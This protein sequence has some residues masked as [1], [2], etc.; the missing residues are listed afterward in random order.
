[1]N[2][3]DQPSMYRGNQQKGN[4]WEVIGTKAPA[5][6]PLPE[7]SSSPSETEQAEQNAPLQETGPTEDPSLMPDPTQDNA[8]EDTESDE[9][10]LKPSP[11]EINDGE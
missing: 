9:G 3:I 1:M 7:T 2:Q 10:L 5:S 4:N 11:E 6:E 8:S